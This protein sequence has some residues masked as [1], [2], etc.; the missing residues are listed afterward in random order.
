MYWYI[1][2]PASRSNILVR[3]QT[4]TC[5]VLSVSTKYAWIVAKILQCQILPLH[6]A[7]RV[8]NPPIIHILGYVIEIG[9]KFSELTQRQCLCFLF[10]ASLA[11]YSH[12]GES[13]RQN[14]VDSRAIKQLPYRTP[15]LFPPCY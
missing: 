9:F 6:C 5:P 8:R 10:R 12:H 15:R 4:P 1:H 13:R 3:V 11:K 2:T 7:L 14:T